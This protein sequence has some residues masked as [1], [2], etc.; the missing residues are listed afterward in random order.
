MYDKAVMVTHTVTSAEATANLV[1]VTIDGFDP[2]SALAQVKAGATNAMKLWDGDLVIN[3]RDI[4]LN[5]DGST[6]LADGDV[7]T[8]MVGRSV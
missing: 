6:D 1:T 3:G 8:L 2:T 4:T 5:N 7:I